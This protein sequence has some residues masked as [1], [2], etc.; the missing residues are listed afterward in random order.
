[1]PA[2][3]WRRQ[4]ADVQWR[5]DALERAGEPR[6]DAHAQAAALSRAFAEHAAKLFSAEMLDG[7]P[8]AFFDQSLCD[9]NGVA[10][11]V[12]HDHANHWAQSENAIQF[13][14]AGLLCAV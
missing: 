3:P 11:I 8:K 12:D 6:S 14:R 5:T 10:R 7:D 9:C 4:L 2:G 13:H 1:L